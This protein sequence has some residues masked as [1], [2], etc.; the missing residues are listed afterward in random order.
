MKSYS[1]IILS[2][3]ACL[4]IAFGFLLSGCGS[5]SKEEPDVPTENQNDTVPNNY[6]PHPRL[7]ISSGDEAGIKAL[8]DSD[9]DLKAYHERILD[10]CAQTLAQ[11]PSVYQK[12][13]K[14]LLSVSRQ[15]LKRVFYLSYA[16]RMT[17]E[18]KYLKRAESEMISAASFKDW[19]PSHYLDVAEMTFGLAIGYD[20]L[21]Y[22]LSPSTR[23]MVCEAIVSKAFETSKSSSYAWFYDSENNWNQ[24]CNGGLACGAIAIYEYA[25]EEAKAIIEKALNSITKPL[26][27]YAPEGGYP[28]GYSYWS[29][30]TTYQVLFNDSIQRF[31]GDDKGLNSFPGFLNSAYFIQFLMAPSGQCFN[32]SDSTP[33]VCG[34]NIICWF[35]EKN[36]DPSLLWLLKKNITNHILSFG[37]ED[38]FLPC[39][40][41]F[42]SRTNAKATEPTTRT[43]LSHG[44]N[45]VYVY[46]S[47]WSSSDD[48]YLG[49]KGGSASVSHGHMDAG[50]FVYE[51]NGVRWAM[52]LGKQDY[53]SL[54]S[55]G[56]DL[57]NMEQDSQRWEVFRLSSQA[58]NTL[59]IDGASHMVDGFADI[60]KEINA[61]GEHGAQVDLASTLG[62]S[63][64]SA[65]RTIK[66][67]S[68]NTLEVTDVIENSSSAA[69]IRWTMQTPAVPETPNGNSIRLIKDDK[70][71]LL[72]V[73]SQKTVSMHIWDNNPPHDYDEANPGTYRVG[74]DM[75]LEPNEKVSVTVRLS[76]E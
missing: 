37:E 46:R 8:I 16:Y 55:K 51:N 22:D 73:D 50:S 6:S 36:N 18:A 34:S 69:T 3:F 32:F 9:E 21:Y 24:V 62:S 23:K 13:G 7:L 59:T 66:V 60:T 72:A 28:E 64:K 38:R 63:V 53:Y 43:W 67:L 5:G 54:E 39:L 4:T 31:Y 44:K 48:I 25:P 47:G 14:R 1:K 11:G 71:A 57:W 40:L 12:I 56:V 45:P 19:N 42:L 75:K 35:A 27:V 41:I 58:H 33:D 2:F 74:Y 29:Y 76:M 15:V 52:D 70:K 30:G 17:G 49:I 65:M 68:D 26:A 20:W 10:Y 61:N